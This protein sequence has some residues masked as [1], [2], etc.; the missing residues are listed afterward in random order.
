MAFLPDGEQLA[1]LDAGGAVQ[2]WDATT[3]ARLRDLAQNV[4]AMAVSSSGELAALVRDAAGLP[5][6]LR[7]FDPAS[8]ASRALPTGPLRL[9]PGTTLAFS[10][11]SARLLLVA[12]D[13]LAVLDLAEDAPP[14]VLRYGSP[15]RRV[16]FSPDSAALVGSYSVGQVARWELASGDERWRIDGVRSSFA[17][18]PDGASLAIAATPTGV[19][20]AGS[21]APQVG[22]ASDPALSEVAFA[23]T[24]LA[25]AGLTEQPVLWDATTGAELRRFDAPRTTGDLLSGVPS[26]G[27]LAFS[28]DGTL[29]AAGIAGEARVWDAADGRVLRRLRHDGSVSGVLG[30]AFSPDGTLL[31]SR[32]LDQ[33]VLWDLAAGRRLRTLRLED[34]QRF[35]SSVAF[36]PDGRTLATG[37]HL[38]DY[39]PNAPDLR[40]WDASTGEELAALATDAIG[41]DLAFSPDG[42]MLAGASDDGRL[43]L[44]GTP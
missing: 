1:T 3:G 7:L 25:F 43:L 14:L 12:A 16:A 31:A 9:T 8:G 28:P 26:R 38:N 37:T 19:W 20:D 6:E 15:A 36:S 4:A 40:L 35:F 41:V 13:A 32:S 21:G 34:G 17:I 27:G 29:L 5:Q 11:D 30:L 22:G 18:S 44:W 39:A 33:I 10:P 2:L 24:G 42:R 23:P